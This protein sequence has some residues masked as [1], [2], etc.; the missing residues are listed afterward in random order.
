MAT[1][2]MSGE[3]W[4][5][6]NQAR[7]PNSDSVDDLEPGF[8][9]CVEVFLASLR[10]AGA[11]IRVTSTRRNAVRAHLMHYSWRLGHGDI[12][13]ADVPKKSGLDIEW[14]HGDEERSKEAAMEMVKLFDL[15][16]VAALRSNHVTGKAIDMN[17]SW[18]GTLV[19]T[20]PAPLLSRIESLPRNGQNRELHQIAGTVFSV[21][22]LRTD[23]PHWSHNGR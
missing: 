5:R 8:R 13:A 6:A 2:S 3:G 19:V 7:F 12:K 17:V 1:A 15:V 11:T 14:D 23:P 22:K 9:S 16:H 18:R 10:N 21:H 4:W 20:R